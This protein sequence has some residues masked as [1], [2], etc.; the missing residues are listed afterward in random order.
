MPLPTDDWLRLIEKVQKAG[1]KA[2]PEIGIQFGAGG[3]TARRRRTG[4]RRGTLDTGY[5]SCKQ[6]K[7]FL[8]A[9]AYQIRD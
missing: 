2:K 4:E 1:L 3:D 5:A 8:E 9:G 6:T 7:R